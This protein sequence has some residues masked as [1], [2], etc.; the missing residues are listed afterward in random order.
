MT[1]AEIPEWV[2]LLGARDRN[3]HLGGFPITNGY[4]W[5]KGSTAQSS[6]EKDTSVPEWADWTGDALYDNYAHAEPGTVEIYSSG[7]MWRL[8]QSLT[9]LWDRDIKAVLDE[10]L[11]FIWNVCQVMLRIL[12]VSVCPKGCR[13]VCL[14]RTNGR[15]M[16]FQRL[17]FCWLQQ[18]K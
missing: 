6:D 18:P 15:L 1:L 10:R 2:H 5:Q 17:I 14:E 4:F 7:G 3:A 11:L 13:C 16:W 9:V 8:N 12:C